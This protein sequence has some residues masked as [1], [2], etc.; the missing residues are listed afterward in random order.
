MVISSIDTD[1]VIP[2]VSWHRPFCQ[3]ITNYVTPTYALLTGMLNFQIH[4]P[5]LKLYRTLFMFFRAKKGSWHIH[6]PFSTTKNRQI[7]SKLYNMCPFKSLNLKSKRDLASIFI[8][9][10]RPLIRDHFKPRLFFDIGPF[11]KTTTIYSDKIFF[12]KFDILSKI[13]IFP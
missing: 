7:I 3:K 6:G 4:R 2:D 8:L 5:F 11:K 12:W 13:W 1:L 9:W 10:F